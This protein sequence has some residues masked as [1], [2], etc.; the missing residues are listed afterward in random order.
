[1]GFDKINK[2]EQEIDE[3]W[4]VRHALKYY[5]SVLANIELQK[6]QVEYKIARLKEQNKE[7]NIG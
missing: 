1:M 4:P 2:Y 6:K 5:E 7:N 3:F